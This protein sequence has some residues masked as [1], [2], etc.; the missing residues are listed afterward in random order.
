MDSNI[1][2]KVLCASLIMLSLCASGWAKKKKQPQ[3]IDIPVPTTDNAQDA[4]AEANQI[5]QPFSWDSAGD[6]LKYEITIEQFSIIH[7]NWIKYYEHETNDEETQNC[8]IYIEPTLPVGKYRSTIKVYNILG[9]LESSLTSQD[10]FLVRQAYKPEVRNVTYPLYMRSTIYLD[11][12]DNNG[13][14]EVEGRNLFKLPE[15]SHPIPDIQATE[16]Y[17]ESNKR[18]IK[19]ESIIQHDDHNNRK[20]VLQFNMKELDVGKY[21]LV[22]K[23]VSGLHSENT[24]SS[25]FSIKFKKWA[26]FDVEGGYVLPVVLHDSTFQD[27]LGQNIFPLSAQARMSFLPFKHNWGYIGMGLRANVTKIESKQDTFT[28]DGNLGMAHLLAIYQIPMFKRHAFLE[29]HA[30]AGLTYFNNFKFH[31]SNNI[32]SVP[33]NT[34]SL[35]YVAGAALQLYVIPGIKRFYFELSGDYSLTTN[36]DMTFG[37]VLPAIGAGWQF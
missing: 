24:G 23:D 18:K 21:H 20:V 31:F 14:V 28:I 16:Y 34:I 33:L 30:G 3:I 35:S 32:D 1:N 15:T 6:V 36:K 5:R 29:I 8:I 4:T 37:V 7:N 19:P 17:L 26:D 9:I 25:E 27:F 2:R 22:A 11:D 12:L 10:E 13:V